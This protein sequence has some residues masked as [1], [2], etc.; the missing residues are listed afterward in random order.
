MPS[1]GQTVGR[2]DL[3]QTLT[4]QER[5]D[6][7]RRGGVAN[8]IAHDASRHVVLVTG[9]FWPHVFEINLRDVSMHASHVR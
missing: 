5:A 9:K 7:A 8:G 4:A 2:I 1:T 3:S 6:V